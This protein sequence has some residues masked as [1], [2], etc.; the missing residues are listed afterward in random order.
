MEKRHWWRS[1][2]SLADSGNYSLQV[3]W[4]GTMQQLN[5]IKIHTAHTKVKKKKTTSDFCKYAP[6]K[7]Y[8]SRGDFTLSIVRQCWNIAGGSETRLTASNTPKSLNHHATVHSMCSR[9]H[10]IQRNVMKLCREVLYYA[11][12]L[13]CSAANFRNQANPWYSLKVLAAKNGPQDYQECHAPE[14]PFKNHTEIHC[15]T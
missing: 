5:Y 10:R 11:S 14:P 3:K 6:T 2:T 15:V 1:A 13:K 12:Q 7:L 8:F 4:S 9:L